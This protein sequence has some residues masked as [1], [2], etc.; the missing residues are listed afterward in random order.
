M[1]EIDILKQAKRYNSIIEN[2]VDGI[3]I[4]DP[5]YNSQSSIVDFKITHCNSVGCKLAKFPEPAVGKTL[6]QILPHLHDDDQY[7]LH[8]KV[9]ETGEPVQFETTFRTDKGEEYGWFIVSL[10]KLDEGVLSRFVDITEKKRNEEKIENQANLLKSILDAG[11]QSVFALAAVRNNDGEIIDFTISKVNNRFAEMVSLREDEII[12]KSYLRLIDISPDNELF[13]LKCQVLSNGLAIEKEVCYNKHGIES[14]FNIYIARLGTDGVVQTIVDISE[15]KSDKDRLSKIINT[16]RAGIFVFKPVTDESGEIVDFK[17][18]LVNKAIE[19]FFRVSNSF[20]KDQ[21]VSEPFPFYKSQGLFDYFKHT[22]Q[23]NLPNTFDFHFDEEHDLFFNVRTDKMGNE[24]LVTFTDQTPFK[25][26][27]FKLQKSIEELQR[28]NKSLEEFTSAASHDLKEPIRKI[29][30]LLSRLK[31]RFTNL[32]ENDPFQTFDK[33]EEATKRMYLL[34][35]DL[36]EY[37]HL[38]HESSDLEEIDLNKKLK[39][40]LE[41]LD[42]VIEERQAIIKVGAMPVIKGHEQ[43]MQ[44]LFQNLIVNGIKYTPQDAIPEVT[45]TSAMVKGYETGMELSETQANAF[46][47][48][49]TVSDKGIGF[50]QKDAEKIFRVFERLHGNHQYKGSGVGLAIARRVVENHN[51][52]IKAQSVPGH[53]A[54]FTIYL[55]VTK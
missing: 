17:F 26:L 39:R 4:L 54:T 10:Q 44:Q 50:N 42:L 22:Y 14:W 49:I 9:F 11:Q 3:L 55:P 53:G 24:L 16:S 27:E 40:V 43:Q 28:S 15:S 19:D 38:S 18:A 7:Q 34:V 33:L 29:N 13:K 45:I 2:S 52:F 36:L 51:G 25:K 46:Y 31:F 6:L 48:A 23:K 8:K 21:L 30:M 41:D 5:V 12:G 20:L 35:D 32:Q 1:A 37:S 47:H